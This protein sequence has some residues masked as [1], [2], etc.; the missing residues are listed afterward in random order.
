MTG[1]TPQPHAAVLHRLSTDFAA[2]SHQF[3]RV[4]ADLVEL[5]RVLAGR[6]AWPHP[7]PYVAPPMHVPSPMPVAPPY[8]PPPV[9][10]APVPARV[11]KER[12][13]GWIGTLLAT[14]GVAVTLIGVVLLL[15]LAAQAGI[16]RPE[17]RVVAGGVLAAAL[18]GA[19]VRLRGRPGGRVGSTALA[20]TGIAAAY[21]DVIAVTAIYHW[22]SQPIGLVLAAV[23]GGAGLTLARRWD[24]Q[25]LGL[26][27]LVPLIVLAPIV[28][29]GFGLLLGAFMLALSAAALPVQLG[30]DWVWLHAAR[31]AAPI[32]PLFVA[33]ELAGGEG[34]FDPWLA[35][36]CG[37]AALLA[38]ISAL[39]LLPG[40]AHRSATAVLSAVGTTP[41]LG[42]GLVVDRVV[43][44]M[45]IAALAATLLALVL[46]GDRLPGVAGAA[47]RVFGALCAVAA[48]VAVTVAFDGRVAC[49]VLL[50]MAAVV[51]V[52]GR[53]DIVARWAAIGFGAIGAALFLEWAPPGTL[54]QPTAV[55]AAT[56]ASTLASS[57]ALAAAAVAIAWSWRGADRVLWAGAAAIVGYAVTSF[58]VTAGVLIGGQERGFFAGHTVA[59]ICWMAMAAGLFGYALRLPRADRSVPIAG[60]LGLVAAAMAKLFLFDLGTLDGMFRVVV[61]IVGGLLLL[62]MGSGYA[63]LLDRQDKLTTQ[64]PTG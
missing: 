45:M 6:P 43:A 26:L 61:F 59:T 14:A 40:T 5:D 24:S 31:I 29:D 34:R 8:V 20:A 25:R 3:A 49:A 11:R 33:L 52:A 4:S 7:V 12:S 13:D 27:V 46:V 18:V 57:V 17:F 41:L 23:V 36:S 55:S 10:A 16:L 38:L 51:A 48:L 19:A 47:H 32:L 2:L 37:V 60:G 15:V 44:A 58:S 35:C 28:A 9:C 54:L 63:R 62:A 42:V 64:N 39:L 21:M 53:D 1:P 30:R 56:A 22:V 50:A